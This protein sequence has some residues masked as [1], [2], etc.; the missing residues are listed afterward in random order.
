VGTK[1]KIIQLRRS[2]RKVA[3]SSP[4]RTLPDSRKELPTFAK[5]KKPAPTPLRP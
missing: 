2:D 3:I 4:A 1:Q 5:T